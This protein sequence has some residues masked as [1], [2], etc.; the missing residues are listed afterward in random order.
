MNLLEVFNRLFLFVALIAFALPR[1]SLSQEKV[2]NIQRSWKARAFSDMRKYHY[3]T[4][5]TMKDMPDGFDERTIRVY[6]RL[7]APPTIRRPKTQGEVQDYVV[8][9]LEN[10]LVWEEMIAE[11]EELEQVN[12]HNLNNKPSY[13]ERLSYLDLD[14]DGHLSKE[15]ITSHLKNLA[16]KQETEFRAWQKK[17]K[18]K[19]T[20][21]NTEELKAALNRE[22]FNKYDANKDGKI[23][24]LERDYYELAIF[25]KKEKG[26]GE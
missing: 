16:E 1:S 21:E 24:A 20:R 2:S 11:A 10:E 25:L 14:K 6:Q 18:E 13:N 12:K 3:I 15:E 26:G 5:E 9:D 7:G 23:D 8:W 19:Q 4:Q 22:Q 17:E